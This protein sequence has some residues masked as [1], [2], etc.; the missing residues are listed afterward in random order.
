ME[1][2]IFGNESSRK[3]ISARIKTSEYMIDFITTQ[4]FR[5]GGVYALLSS[6]SLLL[7]QFS[8]MLVMV[9]V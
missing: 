2:T 5:S 9:Y 6:K 7:L 1:L 3:I 8:P 4:N